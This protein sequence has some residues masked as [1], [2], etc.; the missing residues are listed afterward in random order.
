MNVCN[1]SRFIQ[2]IRK[3][4]KYQKTTKQNQ[5]KGNNSRKKMV[6]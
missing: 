4:V 5:E 1:F 6:N 3:F 2:K